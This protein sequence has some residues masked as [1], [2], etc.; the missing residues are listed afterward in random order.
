M[1][2]YNDTNEDET[3]RRTGRMPDFPLNRNWSVG[4]H[5]EGTTNATETARPGPS[6]RGFLAASAAVGLGVA[7]MASPVGAD[8]HDDT[9][10]MD[11]EE[12]DD[13]ASEHEEE[14]EEGAR[15]VHLS[16]DAPVVDVYV[17]DELWFEDVEPFATQTEYLEY[18]PGTYTIQFAPAGEGQDAAVLEDE[19]T[20]EEGRYTVAAVGEVCAISGEPLRIVTVED[21]I[22]PTAAGHARVRGVHA[23]PD[24]SPVDFTTSDGDAVFGNLGFG[25]GEYGE[26]SAEEEMIEIREC[27][28]GDLIERF[29]IDFEAGRSYSVFVVGYVDPENAPEDAVENASLRLGITEDAAPGEK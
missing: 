8:D 29:E 25:E 14:I 12:S 2:D 26:I 7:G 17:D 28:S 1:G 24:A 16:P 11:E 6:R 19:V 4:V 23:S 5:A 9:S 27:A 10:S 15:I 20:F 18:V 13:S 21:D 3:G 22:S